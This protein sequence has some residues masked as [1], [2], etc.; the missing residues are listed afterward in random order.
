MQP[1]LLRCTGGE[2]MLTDLR[3]LTEALHEAALDGQLG[4]T[5]LLGWL[6]R[7]RADAS[8]EDAQERSRR[9]D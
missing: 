8:A 5:A 3:H 7:R 9:L 4:L 1:R 2:R 6:R